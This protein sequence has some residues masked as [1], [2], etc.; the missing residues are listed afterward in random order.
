[1]PSGRE[2][3]LH[4]GI[5]YRCRSPKEKLLQFLYKLLRHVQLFL[6]RIMA[7]ILSFIRLSKIQLLLTLA[8]CKDRSFLYLWEAHETLFPAHTNPSCC[9]SV[10]LLL[11]CLLSP[12][13]D[14]ILGVSCNLYEN[15]M[16]SRSFTYVMQ[17]QYSPL[18][19]L[20]HTQWN[21]TG[22]GGQV[23][24]GLRGLRKRI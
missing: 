17:S 24:E 11:C 6:C 15:V 23:E 5:N 1:M 14:R 16:L 22:K 20:K 9:F 10:H 8:T 3:L 13:K 12:L 18:Q 19:N 7:R 2:D 4:W 21:L